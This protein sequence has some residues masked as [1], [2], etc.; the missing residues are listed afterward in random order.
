MRNWKIIGKDHYAFIFFEEVEFQTFPRTITNS[1]C[2]F[3]CTKTV[4]W[5]SYEYTYNMQ[6]LAF[7]C[8]SSLSTYL[9]SFFPKPDWPVSP[10]WNKHRFRWRMLKPTWCANVV[11]RPSSYF[12]CCQS[13]PDNNLKPKLLIR[14][15]L[16]KA[17]MSFAKHMG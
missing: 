3:F 15:Q 10:T 9:R 1:I 6:I 8:V 4:C 16:E 7:L 12:L 13:I 2:S 5:W 17:S 11:G 14:S